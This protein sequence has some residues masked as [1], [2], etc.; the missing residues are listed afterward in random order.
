M[1]RKIY[2]KKESLQI[3]WSLFG[4]G[5]LWGVFLLLGGYELRNGAVYLGYLILFFVG[6]G[7]AMEAM[8]W[9]KRHQECMVTQTPQKGQIVDC[10]CETIYHRRVRGSYTEY[11]YYLIVELYVQGL[12][13]PI[14]IQ[15]DAYPWPVYQTLS[16]PEVDVYYSDTDSGYTL[17][18]FQYKTDKSEPDILP[19]SLRNSLPS[20]GVESWVIIII[21]LLLLLTVRGKYM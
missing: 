13:M 20:K 21:F 7:Q 15:S 12:I 5:I 19:E 18:G 8:Q 9:R 1:R 3:I 16:S 6:I 4:M 11:H 17:D 2:T 14:R 10:I